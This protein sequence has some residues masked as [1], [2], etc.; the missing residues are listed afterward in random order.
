MK[1]VAAI[2][3]EGFCGIVRLVAPLAE[4]LMP[5]GL[6]IPA[7]LR[8]AVTATRPIACL[9]SAL[10]PMVLLGVVCLLSLPFSVLWGAMRAPWVWPAYEYAHAR[11][12]GTSVFDRE[13]RWLG[14]IPGNYDPLGDF[15]LEN[16]PS[17]DHKAVLLD[18]VP[19]SWWG[20]LM[21]L[22]DRRLGS[23]R[24]PAGID[25]AALPKMLTGQGGAST[26]P[27][28]LVRSISHQSPGASIADTLR[29]KRQEL[30]HAPVLMR[31]LWGEQGKEMQRWLA[32]HVPLAVGARGSRM[33]GA[34]YGLE[35]TARTLFGKG[36]GDISQGEQLVL[37]AAFKYNVVLAPGDD[38]AGMKLA[39]KQWQRIRE[40]ASLCLRPDIVGAE[41]V[42]PVTRD[43]QR[44]PLP[45]PLVAPDLDAIL[46]DSPAER[47]A[48]LANPF[49][50][51]RFF[52]GHE[53]MAAIA[54]LRDRFG[55]DWRESV[56][57]IGLTV[58]AV[59]AA[60]C[61]Q[62]ILKAL[63]RV[64]AR[65]SDL[66]KRVVGQAGDATAQVSGA[67]ADD[68]GEI[69]CFHTNTFD[70]IYFG[71]NSKRD[72]NGRYRPEREDQPIG[73]VGKVAAAILFAR[74][75]DTAKTAYCNEFREGIHNANGDQGVTQCGQGDWFAARDV[76][77][78]S[79]N[80]PLLWRLASIDDAEATALARRL[81]LVV[82]P[83]TPSRT[84]LALGTVAGTPRT[85]QGMMAATLHS[86]L[87]R[88]EKAKLPTLI[89]WRDIMSGGNF[90][91]DTKI[92][93]TELDLGGAL[94]T[95]GRR[96][97]RDVL[98]APLNRGT[99]RGLST[100]HPA[101][102]PRIGTHLAKTGTVAVNGRTT[103]T[104]IAGALTW[105][106]RPHSYVLMVG[107]GQP[108][109]D[110]GTVHAGAFAPAAAAMLNSLRG[111]TR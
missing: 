42:V 28:M 91:R 33:G 44:M 87:G 50:R 110:I 25:I 94:S 90:S 89:R 67:L 78:R 24:A 5:L 54:E 3:I 84:A 97:L 37:A 81:N 35:V 26:L 29:R 107:S 75:G 49:R 39:A 73:S 15:T 27:M 106:D 34:L 32:M 65:R 83:D 98:Q 17:T 19:P 4:R 38:D 14:V 70:P 60:N 6:G 93:P 96:Y 48:I 105:D 103:A 61:R 79:L 59:Q 69:R 46:P 74:H 64:E 66:T 43:L 36:A 68:Q 7:L 71:S 53:S 11:A 45:H 76:F 12:M 30:D 47:F 109:S 58:D 23:W 31:H 40:R 63:A 51:A 99:L 18:K 108:T 104:Y 2:V 16:Y 88:T 8:V 77:A 21:Y 13:G 111:N 92:P 62:A 20:C 55:N 56:T 72:E 9:P 80:L 82:P 101:N 86:A 100:W 102:N 41:N 95:A 85:V 57:A 52:A 22:E 1:W 10:L